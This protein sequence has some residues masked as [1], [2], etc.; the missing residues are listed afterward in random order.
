MIGIAGGVIGIVGGLA[1]VIF[2]R[3]FVRLV[4]PRAERRPTWRPILKSRLYEPDESGR[5]PM[6]YVIG[7]GWVLVGCLVLSSE[8][9]G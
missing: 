1:I 7:A 4:Y 6:L 5:V 2:N 8:L 9:T 3:Q